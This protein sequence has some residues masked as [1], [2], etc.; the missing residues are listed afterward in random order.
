MKPLLSYLPLLCAV[1]LL[2]GCASSSSS[3]DTG[4]DLNAMRLEAIDQYP[5]PTRQS[6]PAYPADLRRNNITGEA[7]VQFVVTSTGQVTRVRAIESTHPEFATAAEEAVRK[8]RFEPGMLNGQP[9]SV[10]MEVPIMFE[11]GP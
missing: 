8:W 5:R 9:V 4:G 3:D 2:S 7:L 10:L 11:L 1:L 6:A